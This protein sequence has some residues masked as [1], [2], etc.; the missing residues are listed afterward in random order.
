M[1]ESQ[2]DANRILEHL[3]SIPFVISNNYI[4]HSP[5]LLMQVLLMQSLPTHHFPHNIRLYP[6]RKVLGENIS[7][8]VPSRPACFIWL[9]LVVL[10]M[11]CS[12]SLEPVSTQPCWPCPR[13][14]SCEHGI[15]SLIVCPLFHH[16]F[17]STQRPFFLSCLLC[18]LCHLLDYL[19]LVNLG[20]KCKG[21][22][23]EFH[24]N[25]SG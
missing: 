8:F 6:L 10:T 12:H 19:Y 3:S 5:S 7:Y 15:P 17:L 13:P 1:H 2:Q 14:V 11:S 4:S 25:I 24:F 21:I 23:Q 9:C 18:S 16:R 22:M 20:S